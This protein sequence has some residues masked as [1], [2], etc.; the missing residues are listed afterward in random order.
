MMFDLF[1][2][3]E[4]IRLSNVASALA[5][6]EAMGDD[7]ISNLH[8]KEQAYLGVQGVNTI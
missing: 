5:R 6:I 2:K 1:A 4:I 7:S 3:S 8:E